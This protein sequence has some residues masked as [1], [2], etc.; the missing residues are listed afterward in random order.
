MFFKKKL[1]LY[2]R[3]N[4]KG[5][6]W[7]RTLWKNESFA[8]IVFLKIFFF[9]VFISVYYFRFELMAFGTV[10]H[11][12]FWPFKTWSHFIL[13]GSTNLNFYKSVSSMAVDTQAHFIT[14]RFVGKSWAS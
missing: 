12:L 10:P 3:R 7:K 14:S 4:R 9:F 6:K 1:I 8:S 5:F 11:V 13:I 2:R